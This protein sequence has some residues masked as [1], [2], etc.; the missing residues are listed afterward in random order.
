M[1]VL[2]INGN[3]YIESVTYEIKNQSQILKNLSFIY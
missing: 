2:N 3:L 1:S